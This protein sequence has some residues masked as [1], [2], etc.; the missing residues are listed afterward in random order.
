[1]TEARAAQ[2]Q[3]AEEAAHDDLMSP[4]ESVCGT[5]VGARRLFRQKGFHLSAHQCLL[6]DL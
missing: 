6:A 3:S 4:L 5:T 2:S 1:M